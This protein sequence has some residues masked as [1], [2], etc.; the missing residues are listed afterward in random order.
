M[1][2][3]IWTDIK[4]LALDNL[5]VGTVLL[6]ALIHDGLSVVT[7][8]AARHRARRGVVVVHPDGAAVGAGHARAGPGARPRGAVPAHGVQLL[9][10]LIHLRHQDGG[11]ARDVAE[12]AAG[13]LDSYSMI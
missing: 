9:D 11:V 6:L 4:Q 13:V 2:G 10:A 5:V 8:Q 7:E 3:P 1:S 12:G